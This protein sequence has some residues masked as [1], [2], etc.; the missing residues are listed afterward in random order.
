M[1]K[2]VLDYAVMKLQLG[3]LLGERVCENFLRPF[4]PPTCS[5][6]A[7]HR[8]KILTVLK[9][10]LCSWRRLKII[11]VQDWEW[12]VKERK[13]RHWEIANWAEKW[14]WFSDT[15]GCCRRNPIAVLSQKPTKNTCW[16]VTGLWHKPESS[17]MGKQSSRSLSSR[18]VKHPP[19][20][21]SKAW[22]RRRRDSEKTWV[23][24]LFFS[25]FFF[26]LYFM[27]L[28]VS[29]ILCLINVKILLYLFMQEVQRRSRLISTTSA[30]FSFLGKDSFCCLWQVQI[31]GQNLWVSVF[32]F[33]TYVP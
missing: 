18:A 14:T 2:D 25:F 12:G 27:F 13:G 21:N 19:G 1:D 6:P 30:Q 3:K 10:L 4:D 23:K 26:L 5:C 9:H 33:Q 20:L 7:Q 17:L 32:C 11:K 8:K 24:R 28:I 16:N 22:R 29:E 15:T 31:I